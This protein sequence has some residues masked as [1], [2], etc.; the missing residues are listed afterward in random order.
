VDSAED[1]A[2]SAGVTELAAAE[3]WGAA[4]LDI[5][6][7]CMLRVQLL[8]KST[9]D[10]AAAAELAGAEVWGAATSAIPSI[11]MLRAQ[12]PA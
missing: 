3:D 8:A 9:E 11:C 2:V 1:A 12:L 10:A 4:A 7:I 5:P 6:S